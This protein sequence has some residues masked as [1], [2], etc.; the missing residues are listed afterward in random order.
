MHNPIDFTLT[1]INANI[2]RQLLQMACNTYNMLFHENITLATFI[3][4]VILH[5]RVL[6]HCNL[7]AGQI[8]TIALRAEW[9]EQRTSDH[10]GYAGDDGPYS[11][12]RIPP[13]ARDN[14]PIA[15][16]L[17]VQYP[18]NTY[19]GGGGAD[20]QVGTGGYN[21]IDMTDDILQSYTLS[22]PRNHPLV[23]LMSGDLVKII[24]SQYAIQNWLLT[25][26]IAYDKWFTNLHASA[27]PVL[28]KLVVLATKQWIYNNLLID[29]DR[30]CQECG[31]DIGTVRQLVDSY[32]DSNEKFDETM[33]K[34]RGVSLL[35]VETRRRIMTYQW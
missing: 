17:S 5:D 33:L 10:A 12:Y 24:P 4:K 9:L 2:P 23:V 20:L 35:D 1:E 25:C 15:N 22:S 16:V 13:E 31:A 21:L 28:A 27:I 34:W 11:L 32:A 8:K 19:C 30:A 3:T 26:R 14:M 18:F 29:I 6:K 7:S